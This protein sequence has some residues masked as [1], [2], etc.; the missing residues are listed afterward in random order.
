MQWL[1]P[2]LPEKDVTHPNEPLQGSL[3]GSAVIVHNPPEDRYPGGP[4]RKK[5]GRSL[6]KRPGYKGSV[7]AGLTQVDPFRR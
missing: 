5:M 3:A 1:E 6:P 7:L 2:L 4:Q